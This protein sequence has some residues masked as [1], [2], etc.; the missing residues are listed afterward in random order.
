[1]SCR[2]TNIFS[3]DLED[4]YMVSAFETVVTRERWQDYE[5]RIERSTHL[6]LDLMD[7]QSQPNQ[8]IKGTFFCLGWIAERHPDLI[9]EIDTRG[10]EIGSHGYD[11]RMISS[12]TPQVFREDIRR[13]RAVLEDLIGC[14]VL[15]YRA[16]SYSITN[17][18][19]W[20]LRIIAEEGYRYDS[21][22]FPVHH[23]IYGIPDAPRFPHV[24]SM[25]GDEPCEF[26]PL[27]LAG[28]QSNTR[29]LTPYSQDPLTLLEFPPSTL[30]FLNRN[31]PVSGGG[32]FRLLP[33]AVTRCAIRRIQ[34]QRGFPFVFY[35]H[36]WELDE[37]QPRMV[38]LPLRSRFRHYL[39]LDKTA[40]RLRQLLQQVRFGPFKQ[41]LVAASIE[42]SQ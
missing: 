36:P 14:R 39:N 9:K 15:G 37:D 6:L 1:M 18:T 38:G 16:P 12:I 33:L 17:E 11:H 34:T 27:S 4:Y 28:P 19:L 20:A 24:V 21:S 3:V 42:V 2:P 31:L 30:R 25:N 26:I 22:I 5:S 35:I 32:Y 13:S 41:L 23:D 29:C 10:H 7:E 8:P 40:G